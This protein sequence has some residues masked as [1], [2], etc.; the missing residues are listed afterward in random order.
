MITT[1]IENHDIFRDILL[2]MFNSI[3]E[4]ASVTAS[5]D[6][7]KTLAFAE[8]LAHIA[9]LKTIPSPGFNTMH[10]IQLY[11]KPVKIDEQEIFTIPNRNTIALEIL[12]DILDIRSILYMWKA[13]LFDCTLVLISTSQ[14]L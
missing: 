12:F 7:D 6:N 13:M 2:Q 5:Q 8:M 14:S 4:P 11:N 3:T 9:Y 1:E 10:R